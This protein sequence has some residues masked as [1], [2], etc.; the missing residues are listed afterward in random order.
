MLKVNRNRPSRGRRVRKIGRVEY[1]I[2]DGKKVIHDKRSGKRIVR[3]QRTEF[4][5]TEQNTNW[6][7]LGHSFRGKLARRD[8]DLVLRYIINETP[9]GL[10]RDLGRDIVNIISDYAFCDCGEGYLPMNECCGKISCVNCA[11]QCL[12]CEVI[13]CRKCYK[14]NKTG[15]VDCS[16]SVHDCPFC[17]SNR[18]FDCYEPLCKDCRIFV[19]AHNH[20]KCE[21]CH[22]NATCQNCDYTLYDGTS[23][24]SGCISCELK[25]CEKCMGE[26]EICYECSAPHDEE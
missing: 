22:T 2:V 6:I 11:Y 10:L 14:S 15:C 9:L 21:T 26:E 8:R 7:C 23:D 17:S 5:A 24:L 20:F 18:C 3:I 25:V 16:T 13:T 4:P 12:G 19:E 1:F